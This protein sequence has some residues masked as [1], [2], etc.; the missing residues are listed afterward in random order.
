MQAG[1]T[2][3][4]RLADFIGSW[5]ITRRIVDDLAGHIVR[6]EGAATFTPEGSGLL[7][8][9]EGVLQIPDQ[10][11]VQAARTYLWSES[12]DGLRVDFHDGRPFHT[13]LPGQT[14]QTRHDCAPDLYEVQ[15]DFT[16]WPEWQ[17]VWS[18][19]GPRKRYTMTS[20]YRLDANNAAI[21]VR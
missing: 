1:E 6:F 11:P 16:A 18:V 9:E 19:R 15:Y 21:R 7:Y 14:A 8:R 5:R 12:A 20:T 3:G 10:T 2:A 13:I 4:P 17:A